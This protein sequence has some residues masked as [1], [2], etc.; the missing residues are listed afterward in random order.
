MSREYECDLRAAGVGLGM[1]LADAIVQC[2]SPK[3]LI[4][5]AMLLGAKDCLAVDNVEIGK[6]VLLM[7]SQ[8]TH[9]F[10]VEKMKPAVM[11]ALEAVKTESDRRTAR[12]N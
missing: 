2:G 8:A 10:L 7:Q 1:A 9:H 4:V 11:K 6:A 5:S 3:T 12:Q